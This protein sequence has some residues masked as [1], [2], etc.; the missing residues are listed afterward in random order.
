MT[1]GKVRKSQPDVEQARSL[2]KM[3]KK[4]FQAIQTI[5]LTEETSSILFSQSYESLRQV[6]EALC[7]IDGFKVYSHEAY[8][9][10]LKENDRLY[11]SEVFDRLRRLRNGINYYGKPVSLK[12]TQNAFHDIEKLMKILTALIDD[13]Q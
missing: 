13:R 7:L 11:E 8:T 2:V 4:N 1:N 6:V 10:Y 9:Y 5:H 12:V 3:A